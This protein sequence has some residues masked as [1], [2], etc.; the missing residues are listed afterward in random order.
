MEID[1]LDLELFLLYLQDD[2]LGDKDLHFRLEQFL[3]SEAR[4]N[5]SDD[6]IILAH[7]KT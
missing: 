4:H 2:I 6:F 7:D 3:D 1:R 5:P